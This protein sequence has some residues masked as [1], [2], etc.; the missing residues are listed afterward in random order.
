MQVE[1]PQWIEVERGD[2]FVGAERQLRSSVEQKNRPNIVLVM[3]GNE[4]YYKNFKSLCYGLNLV[5]QCVRYQNFGKGM[6]LSVA[7][8]VLRQINSKLG[9]DLYN[10]RLAPQLFAKTMLIGMDVCH[11]GPMSIVGFC[12]S[13]NES[14]SQ[15]WSERIVQKKGQEIVG[16]QLKE[17]IK[18]S[19]QCFA[20]RNGDYPEHFI[21]YRD[22]VGDGMRRQVLQAEV[23]QLRDAIN[24]TYNLAKK[25]PYITVIIVNKRITQ[26]FFLE[27]GRNGLINPPSGCLIDTKIVENEDSQSEYDFYLVPQTTTQGCILPTHFYVPFNDS[28]IAKGVIEK[29]TFDLC[30]Y[31]FN[32]AGPIKVPAPCMYAHKIAELFENLGKEARHLILSDRLNQSYHYL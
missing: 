18:R 1:E 17:A 27:D 29:L 22:G 4:R 8:N 20:D 6:N 10:I 28:P 25:K 7:S 21:I 24:E 3:L 13:I 12:A 14:R 26:R 5:S 19:L 11:S 16:P 30:H 32:W 31:Y 9:G 15:Y 2:D 23:T